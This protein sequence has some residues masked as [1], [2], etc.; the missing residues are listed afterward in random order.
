MSII[1]RITALVDQKGIKQNDICAALGIT[2]GTYSTWKSRKTDPP[3]K[4]I[5]CICELLGVSL[6]FLLTGKETNETFSAPE[7]RKY[8][9][10]HP[11]D[12]PI[13]KKYNAV[14]RTVCLLAGKPK[15]Y[16]L[17]SAARVPADNPTAFT[18]AQ[19]CFLA[20]LMNGKTKDIIEAT[21]FEDDNL[22]EYS[23]FEIIKKYVCFQPEY[24]SLS[25]LVSTYPET[26]KWFNDINKLYVEALLDEVDSKCF[27][28]V[29][30]SLLKYSSYEQGKIMALFMSAVKEYE[31]SASADKEQ[32]INDMSAEIKG[33]V[34]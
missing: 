6:S 27:T 21:V 11:E 24:S 17:L 13:S 14:C 32:L 8:H 29:A 7:L 10:N 31:I 19:L 20:F 22:I 18:D 1:D 15:G 4:Y 12:D 26:E 9:W 30:E 5:P 3:A 2:S 28:D 16:A 25:E 23:D 34:S 33:N